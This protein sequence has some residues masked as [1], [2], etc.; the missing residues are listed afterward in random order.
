MSVAISGP[1]TAIRGARVDVTGLLRSARR[2]LRAIGFGR[3]ELSIAL[4]DDASIAELNGR[5]RGRAG[6]TDVLSFSLLEGEFPDHR[7]GMLGDV[8]I[9]VETAAR[10]AARRHRSLDEIVTRLLVHGVLHLVGYDHE[11][12]DEARRMAAEERRVRRMLVR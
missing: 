8:V 5:W 6:P 3:A 7:G 2:I 10:E 11:E 9:S 4:V 1:P 12:E